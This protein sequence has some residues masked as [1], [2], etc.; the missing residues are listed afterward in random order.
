VKLMRDFVCEKVCV[1]DHEFLRKVKGREP[2][3]EFLTANME[4]SSQRKVQLMLLDSKGKLIGTFDDPKA[5]KE[6]APA[7]LRAAKK[8]REE[9]SKRLAAAAPP[10]EK[11]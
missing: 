3:S 4:K 10:A 2:I 8:A 6:G 9:N 7:L 11:V 5:L 1:S